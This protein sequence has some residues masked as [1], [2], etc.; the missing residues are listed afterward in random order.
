M[1]DFI[2]LFLLAIERSSASTSLSAVIVGA[3][4][5]SMG[6]GGREQRREGEKLG[7]GAVKSPHRLR[8]GA[9]SASF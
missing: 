7:E 2:T 4:Y 5:E 3:W 8:G 1:Y 9:S 6:E